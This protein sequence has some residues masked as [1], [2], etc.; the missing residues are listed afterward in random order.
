MPGA[1]F[2]IFAPNVTLDEWLPRPARY[3]DL[4]RA[5][6]LLLMV[7]GG[8]SPDSVIE[9]TPHECRH[10][11]LSAGRQLAQ[12]GV[13]GENALESLGH[14]ERGSKMPAL[15]DSASC[16]G[17]LNTRKRICDALR[18]GWRPAS[19]GELPKN[20]ADYSQ[21]AAMPESVEATPAAAPL[22]ANGACRVYN[23]KR[24]RIHANRPPSTK[25]ICGWW[26]CVTSSE[27][28]QYASFS[29][30]PSGATLCRSCH[31]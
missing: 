21:A 1:D 11:Q 16:V 30:F 7:H 27:P 31:T 9:Y 15:Y 26:V 29:S 24:N 8:E 5:L 20:L 6:H 18:T 13:I 2:M 22:V 10:F 17:E 19:D 28:S 4:S 23:S 25:S 14:W 12:Q 3:N